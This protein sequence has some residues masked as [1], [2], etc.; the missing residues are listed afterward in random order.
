MVGLAFGAL[1]L[2]LSTSG[3]LLV[4]H[5]ELERMFEHDRHVAVVP[6]G[7][8]RVPLVELARRIAPLAPAG[9]R[10]FRVYPSSSD[11]QT[12]QFVFL[13]A[14]GTTRWS[15]F[16]VPANGAVRWSGPDQ[17]LLTPWL[18]HLHM[19]LHAGR[20]GYV[21][22]GAAGAGLVFLGLSGLYLYRDRFSALWR[23]PFRLRLG[24]RVAL[25]DLHKW[26]GVA[27]LYFVLVLGL[28][29]VLYVLSILQA[30]SA[31]P[32]AGEPFRVEALAPVEPLFAAA[33]NRFPDAEILRLQFPARRGGVVVL[34]LLHRDAPVWR[35]FSRMEFD[36]ESGELRRIRAAAEASAGEQF[37]SMLAPL[38]FGFYGAPWVKWAYFAG[39]LAP[40]VLALSG[41][42]LWWLRRNRRR[43]DRS[44]TAGPSERR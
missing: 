5:H 26:V 39:G 41:A 21:A 14:N 20:A 19:N 38:H 9:H 15:A 27:A 23:H 40:A 7:V 32:V 4:M 44:V 12:H 25:A 3:S 36:A 8:G 2:V 30:K 29:G 24:W 16:A 11:N 31:T 17:S 28:T 1:L 34:L 33:R 6:A 18:L 13:A 22:T 37:A 10:L 42:G 43:E 35:K